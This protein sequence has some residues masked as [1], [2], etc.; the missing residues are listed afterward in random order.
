[1]MPCALFYCD[2]SKYKFQH[3]AI[4]LSTLAPHLTELSKVFQAVCFNL[5]QMK[6]PLELSISMLYNS[7]AKSEPKAN[8]EKFD[9]K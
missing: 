1:M 6:A 3:V 8:C 5:A 2:L 4:L 9:S 7:S